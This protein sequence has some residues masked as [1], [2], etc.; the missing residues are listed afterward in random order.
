MHLVYGLVSIYSGMVL[1][2]WGQ[3]GASTT[4]ASQEAGEAATAHHSRVVGWSAQRRLSV[5]PRS[6]FTP[7]IWGRH[8]HL[9][10][11]GPRQHQPFS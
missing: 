7:L 11:V 8:G 1:T 2:S 3:R 5:E 9:G 6:G 4:V 10:P